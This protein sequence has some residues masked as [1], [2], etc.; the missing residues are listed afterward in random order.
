L[1]IIE[2]SSFGV[3]SAVVTLERPQSPLRFVLFPMVHL[4]SVAFYREVAVRLR[5]CQLV[6]A[7]GIRGRTASVMALTM[8]YRLLRHSRRLGLVVQEL[9]LGGL[10]VPV[11]GPDMT[12]AEF[13]QRWGQSAVV[14]R[15]L[16]WCL[17]PVFAA[18]MTLF[19][20]RRFLARAL[21][22]LDDLPALDE[23]VPEGFEDLDKL[24]VDERDRLLLDALTAVHEQRCHEP[25][26]VAVVYGAGHVRAVVH[27][28][29]GRF[30]YR[31]VRAEWLDVFEF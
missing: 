25:I 8:A 7:E 19:G 27:G 31:A 22:S 3:R 14:P 30:G 15:L 24:I 20:S 2:V 12:A 18:G 9:D 10:G 13:K 21:G 29:S 28:L 16:V 6:V 4:G 23:R 26:V 1:Q 5:E 17:V 11:V